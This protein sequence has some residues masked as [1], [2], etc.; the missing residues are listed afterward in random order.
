MSGMASPTSPAAVRALYDKIGAEFPSSYA[1]KN[2]D[3]VDAFAALT[4]RLDSVGVPSLSTLPTLPIFPASA[5]MKDPTSADSIA[6]APEPIIPPVDL[7]A[8]LR[9]A[10]DV[11]HNPRIRELALDAVQKL[12]A[13]GLL[14][15]PVPGSEV[16]DAVGTPSAAKSPTLSPTAMSSSGSAADA[17]TVPA[18]TVLQLEATTSASNDDGISVPGGGDDA[19]GSHTPA[20]PSA[21]LAE[22]PSTGATA[23]A[24]RMLLED[25]ISASA[26]CFAPLSQ[27]IGA[28][29]AIHIQVIKVILTATTLPSLQ[30]HDVSLLKSLQTCFN[31]FLYSRN[32]NIITTARAALTQILSSVVLR[33]VADLSPQNARDA[34][35]SF[36]ALCKLA[37]KTFAER[38]GGGSSAEPSPLTVRCRLLAL[39]LLMTMLNQL[40]QAKCPVVADILTS[41]GGD[42]C[43]AISKNATSSHAGLFENSLA[44]FSL[45]LTQHRHLFKPQIPV[46]LCDVYLPVLAGNATLQHKQLLLQSLAL[47]CTQPQTLVDLYVNFD[48]DLHMPSCIEDLLHRCC[49]AYATQPA[50]AL[51][52]LEGVLRSLAGWMVPAHPMSP[53]NGRTSASPLGEDGQPTPSPTELGVGPAESKASE[54]S[55][56]Q[57]KQHTKHGLEL[58]NQSP[59]KGIDYL[60]AFDVVP[61]NDPHAL[62]AF[63]HA[64]PPSKSKLGEFLGELDQLAVMHAFVDALDFHGLQFVDA[65]RSFLALFRLP[66]EAQ[67]IDRFMEKFADKYCGDNPD[68]FSNADTAY[69][70][71][72]S[73]IMLNTDLHSKQVKRRMT[74]DDFLK[75]NRRITDSQA[76]SDEYFMKIYDDI[77]ANEIHLEDVPNEVTE[78]EDQRKELYKRESHVIEKRSQQKMKVP[79]DVSAWKTAELPDYARLIFQGSFRSILQCLVPAKSYTG[80]RSAL[81]IATRFALTEERQESLEALAQLTGLMTPSSSLASPSSSNAASAAAVVSAL[82]MQAVATLVQVA[83]SLAPSINESW[84]VVLQGLSELDKRSIDV[85]ND[86]TVLIDCIFTSTAAIPAP[87]LVHFIMA[88]CSV[89]RTEVAEK[90]SYSLKRL[91]EVA[92]YN[93]NR[94][95]F[96]FNQ[97]FPI[98]LEHFVEVVQLDDDIATFA[99]DSLRQL[100]SKFLERDELAHFN[101]QLEFMRPFHTMMTVVKG[102]ALQ[103]IILTSLHQLIQ[104]RF[105]NLKSGWK[106]VFPVLNAGIRFP[107]TE[108]ILVLVF[109]HFAELQNQH[110]TVD[111]IECLARACCVVEKTSLLDLLVSVPSD[112]IAVLSGVVQVILQHQHLAMRSRATEALF[113]LLAGGDDLDT[114]AIVERVLLPLFRENDRLDV[115]WVQALQQFVRLWMAGMEPKVLRG[116]CQVLELS[117]VQRSETVAQCAV[118]CFQEVLK[119]LLATAAECEHAHGHTAAAAS[120]S[121]DPIT[122]GLPP[123]SSNT[124]SESSDPATAPVPTANAFPPSRA[125]HAALSRSD[126]GTSWTLVIACMV[127]M[128]QQTLPKDLERVRGPG[129][130]SDD[131]TALDPADFPYVTQMCAVHLSILSILQP[132]LGAHHTAVPLEFYTGALPFLK[133]SRDFAM[134]FNNNNELRSRIWKAGLTSNPPN[135]LRQ[136][137][138]G[139]AL[140]IMCLCC[141]LQGFERQELPYLRSLRDAGEDVVNEFLQLPAMTTSSALSIKTKTFMAPN[142]ALLYTRLADLAFNIPGKT[143]IMPLIKPFFQLGIDIVKDDEPAARV[144]VA[145]FLQL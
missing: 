39:E 107:M 113:H 71:A 65:L 73:V 54:E 137:S 55:V 74:E 36:R 127:A 25:V 140:T 2:K 133:A 84:P 141:I 128:A 12:L 53:I 90:R 28:E 52:V 26:S 96:E 100:T 82:D 38:D 60:F 103:E 17:D 144:A 143:A 61:R 30:V 122:N 59:Q 51:A 29:E 5:A 34:F 11:R 85:P 22:V 126:L 63:L 8:P 6:L 47:W 56:I 98:I 49:Q 78:D 138:L 131:P 117:A 88:L 89:S 145:T 130:P 58:F 94:I 106:G 13:M 42:L 118:V 99:V 23:P 40:S 108:Q 102:E 67:K 19:I 119:H 79:K 4:K 134:S 75:N 33:T 83:H 66:G 129:A 10:L 24:R 139:T 124:A 76:L 135:L 91:V 18:G 27:S 35:I 115:V 136:E 37:A 112:R 1:K 3:V 48:C 41:Q 64:N 123:A 110:V 95:R 72:F 21:I 142:V 97:F 111:Y 116:L 70:L 46:L 77:R 87:A 69:A 120:D 15:G 132:F 68:V 86:T 14:N 101:S 92:Y 45:I 93:F 62:A 121:A 44:L 20:I 9:L 125:Q 16:A 31:F 80:L 105:R 57:M 109:Q 43:V 32:K 114:D 7:F 50:P 81:Q 104:A